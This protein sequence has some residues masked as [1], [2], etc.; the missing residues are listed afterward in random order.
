MVAIKQLSSKDFDLLIDY[1]DEILK[2]IPKGFMDPYT[3]HTSEF[4]PYV[5]KDNLFNYRCLYYSN[6][7]STEVIYFKL[8]KKP[9]NSLILDL[10]Y[11]DADINNAFIEKL[12]FIFSEIKSSYND[13]NKINI[14]LFEKDLDIYI[15]ALEKLNFSRE[16]VYFDEFGLG[17]NVFVY[18]R[19]L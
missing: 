2:G 5:I 10:I 16:V 8:R 9:L 1:F 17:N 18:S 7:D 11:F 3:T 19:Y 15:N 12:N 6:T 4:S 13:M 14:R